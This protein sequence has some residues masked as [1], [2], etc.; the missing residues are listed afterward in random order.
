MIWLPAHRQVRPRWRSLIQLE[1]PLR[2][3]ESSHAKFYTPFFIHSQD[4]HRD[5]WLVHLSRHTGLGTR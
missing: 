1:L 3:P 4:S 5:L 2:G